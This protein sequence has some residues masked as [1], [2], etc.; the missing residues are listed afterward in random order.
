MKVI[1]PAELEAAYRGWTALEFSNDGKHFLLSSR[2]D[3][4]ATPDHNK[5]LEPAHV[6]DDKR[7][8]AGVAYNPRCNMLATADQEL[9]FWIADPHAIYWKDLLDILALFFDDKLSVLASPP[10]QNVK[11]NTLLVCRLTWSRRTSTS[12]ATRATT[13]PCPPA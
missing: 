2:L 8:A 4:L 3:T 9:L 12:S 6:L 11:T 13:L 5:M 7:E 1:W 10:P